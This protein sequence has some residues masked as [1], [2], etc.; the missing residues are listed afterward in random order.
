MEEIWKDVVG[1]EGLYQVSNFGKVRSARSNIIMSQSC[2]RGYMV[3]TLSNPRKQKKIHRLVAEAF[4]P[5]PNNL[6]CINHKDENKAH[7]TVDNLEW[8]S[9][10]QNNLYG[11]RQQRASKSKMI[12]VIQYD[13]DGNQIAEFDSAQSIENI[14]GYSDAQICEC[15]KGRSAV[16]YGFQWRYKGDSTYPVGKYVPPPSKRAKPVLQFGTDGKLIAKY[17]S[18]EEMHLITGFS[19]GNVSMCCHGKKQNLYGYIWRYE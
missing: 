19:C 1:Y 17:H 16:G 11:T 18:L 2:I 8:C 15:C 7:N 10:R 12:P 14:L 5:N 3:V 13:L 6:P 9:I 4:I